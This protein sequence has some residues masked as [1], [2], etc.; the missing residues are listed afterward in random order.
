MSVWYVVTGTFAANS[1]SKMVGVVKI[2]A[3]SGPGSSRSPFDC[4]V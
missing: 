2:P 3:F 4:A 1:F